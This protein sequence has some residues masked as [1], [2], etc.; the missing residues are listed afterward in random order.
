MSRAQLLEL[1]VEFKGAN[2]GPRTRR[3]DTRKSI[4]AADPDWDRERPHRWWDPG[5]QLLKAIRGY[6]RW[7]KRGVFGRFVSKFY[8]L[9]HRFWSVVTGSDI[10]LNCNLGGGLQ[11]PHPNGIVIHPDVV[12]G[13]N[14]LIFQQVTLGCGGTIPG[15]PILRGHVDIGAGAKLLGGIVVGAHAHIGANSVVLIDV[16]AGATAVGIPARIIDKPDVHS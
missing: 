16:P 4:S 9:K 12:V 2:L 11:L 13:P 6:Q 1:D 8:V 3:M 5:A 10:P 15:Q 14:C 7:K